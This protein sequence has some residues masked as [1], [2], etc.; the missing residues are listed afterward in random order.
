MAHTRTWQRLTACACALLLVKLGMYSDCSDSISGALVLWKM[1][2][3]LHPLCYNPARNKECEVVKWGYVVSQISHVNK[4]VLASGL[5]WNHT[6][7][8]TGLGLLVGRWDF[9][10][11]RQQQLICVILLLLLLHRLASLIGAAISIQGLQEKETKRAETGE[12]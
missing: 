10:L 5:P 6:L 12:K 8:S 3:A 9:G 4:E 7:T 1:A 11:C 2:P